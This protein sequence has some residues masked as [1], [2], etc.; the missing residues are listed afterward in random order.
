MPR[1]Q[2]I[3]G[4]QQGLDN[5]TTVLMAHIHV[6]KCMK[7]RLTEAQCLQESHATDGDSEAQRGQGTS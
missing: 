2:N 3:P 6:A 7:S 4:P 5:L 1:A